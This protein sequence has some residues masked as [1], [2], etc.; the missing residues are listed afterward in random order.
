VQPYGIGGSSCGTKGYS[1]RYNSQLIG[2]KC[3]V[4]LQQELP[5]VNLHLHFDLRVCM[6]VRT[7][8]PTYVRIY[9]SMYLCI[10]VSMYLCMYVC[11]YLSIYLPIYI[12]MYV[13]ISIS[14][15]KHLNIKHH[16]PYNS[17]RNPGTASL[18][19]SNIYKMMPLLKKLQ[20]QYTILINWQFF[21]VIKWQFWC[22]VQPNRNLILWHFFLFTSHPKGRTLW[23]ILNN[24]H[25]QK[26]VGTL[27]KHPIKRYPGSGGL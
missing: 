13:W 7:Y 10:Y 1:Y 22:S 23:F 11:I 14:L 26:K 25:P 5:L 9:I 6:Y 2:G 16:L 12:Y 27:E 19:K 20:F 17:T 4:S 21:K 3:D 15:Y 8:V 24:D 18:L